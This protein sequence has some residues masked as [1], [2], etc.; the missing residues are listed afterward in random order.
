MLLNAVH[1]GA[2]RFGKKAVAGGIISGAAFFC[3][4]LWALNEK[5]T[6]GMG[7]MR[8]GR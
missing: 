3:A 7:E 5:E 1:C 2:R 4:E 8:E 6:E